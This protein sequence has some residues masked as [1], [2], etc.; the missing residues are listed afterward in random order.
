MLK[1]WIYQVKFQF[2]VMTKLMEWLL[3]GFL[4]FGVWLSIIVSEANS[5]TSFQWYYKWFPV[6]FLVLFGMYAVLTVLYRVFTFNNCESAAI[7]L[8]EVSNICW[9]LG[10]FQELSS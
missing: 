3:G 9:I 10:N 5:S 6:I 4:M 1:N 7:E 8:Q 2:T